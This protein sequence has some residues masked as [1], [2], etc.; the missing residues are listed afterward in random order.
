[1][2]TRQLPRQVQGATGAHSL[3][4]MEILSRVDGGMNTCGTKDDPVVGVLGRQASE[5]PWTSMCYDSSKT[6]V[7][8]VDRSCTF[9]RFQTCPIPNGA[10]RTMI[11]RDV[12]TRCS[13]KK[14][15]EAP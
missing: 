14:S 10:L 12:S 15:H 1:M 4:Q 11:C 13:L 6:L 2:T 7:A 9:A 3:E 8:G 5:C